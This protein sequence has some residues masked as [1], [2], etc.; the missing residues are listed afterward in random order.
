MVHLAVE[1]YPQSLVRAI[2]I[3]DIVSDTV[4]ASKFPAMK[5][6]AFQIAPQKSFSRCEIVTQLSA[7]CS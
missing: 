2:K 1:F 4:L 6:R 5:F 7:K 3:E